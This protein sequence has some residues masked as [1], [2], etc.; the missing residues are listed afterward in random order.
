MTEKPL[1]AVPW[2]SPEALSRAGATIGLGATAA[3]RPGVEPPEGELDRL[4]FELGRTR[5][6]ALMVVDAV[7]QALD[8]AADLAPKRPEGA[9][10]TDRAATMAERVALLAALARAGREAKALLARAVA[11]LQRDRDTLVEC[12]SNLRGGPDGTIE[13][14]PGT[15]EDAVVDE[16]AE[17]DALIAAAGGD[18]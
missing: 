6:Q 9:V 1:I 13:A 5:G 10:E 4:L 11:V 17:L 2:P 18:T 7:A 12:H 16:V 3:T 8:A 14:V 15:L